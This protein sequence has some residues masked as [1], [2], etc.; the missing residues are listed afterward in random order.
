MLFINVSNLNC[1]VIS[2]SYSLIIGWEV[3]KKGNLHAYPLEH[4]NRCDSLKR[5]IKLIK[6]N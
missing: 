5:L 4:L 6:E 2:E 1:K 3:A